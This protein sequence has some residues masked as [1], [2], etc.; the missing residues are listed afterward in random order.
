MKLLFAI[1]VAFGYALSGCSDNKTPDTNGEDPVRR[2]EKGIA[3]LE[4]VKTKILQ[5]L[6]NYPVQI[7]YDVKKN[8]SLVN[9]I[10]GTVEIT[11]IGPLGPLQKH[12]FIFGFNNGS[13]KAMQCLWSW[14]GGEEKELPG[15]FSGVQKYFD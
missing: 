14:Q 11:Q 13:W 15:P 12:K 1:C 7:K 2:F 9:P 10:I 5:H 4:Q 8:D 3:K 6:E